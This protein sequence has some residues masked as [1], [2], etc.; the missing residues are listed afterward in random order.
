M[1]HLIDILSDEAWRSKLG[2]RFEEMTAD[3]FNVLRWAIVVGFTR[4]LAIE[5][6][7]PWFTTLYWAASIMLFAY[8]A[9]RFLLRPEI[10]IFSQRDRLW[11]KIT[12][13]A[14]NYGLC[15]LLF[16]FV[17]Y[18]LGQFVDGIAQYRFGTS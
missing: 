12:Q 10:P 14:I 2:R 17:M 5:V 9:S 11:K 16:M 8:L 15:M 4:F 7:S 3:V 1:N 13:S 18:V 6:R